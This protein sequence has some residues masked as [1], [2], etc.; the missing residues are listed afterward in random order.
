MGQSFCSKGNSYIVSSLLSCGTSI[1]P[2]TYAPVCR[3]I[4]EAKWGQQTLS[5]HD[6]SFTKQQR[7]TAGKKKKRE[8]ERT[9][10]ENRRWSKRAKE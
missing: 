4:T 7:S 10:I 6:P 3:D 2:L 8:R 1:S 5:L 9:Q